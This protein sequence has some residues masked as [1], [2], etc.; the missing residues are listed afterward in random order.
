MLVAVN[1][2][3]ALLC[4]L[5]ASFSVVLMYD[6]ESKP[7][8]LP[9]IARALSLNNFLALV[10]I[11]AYFFSYTSDIVLP[12]NVISFFNFK[13]SWGQKMGLQFF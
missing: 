10:T 9:I 6:S 4:I 8:F 11:S 7:S 1:V 12:N 13:Y 3:G 5:R 2:L